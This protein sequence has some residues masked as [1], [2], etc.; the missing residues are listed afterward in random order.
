MGPKSACKVEQVSSARQHA[1]V[2]LMIAFLIISM[3]ILLVFPQPGIHAFEYP[4]FFVPFCAQIRHVFLLS[5]LSA[6]KFSKFL[7]QRSR[8]NSLRKSGG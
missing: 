3:I 6:A 1:L 5:I 8:V 4:N 7:W 2:M